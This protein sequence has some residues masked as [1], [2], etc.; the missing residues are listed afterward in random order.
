MYQGVIFLTEVTM[1]DQ[2]SFPEL[3]EYLSMPETLIKFLLLVC[4]ECLVP[5]LV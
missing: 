2:K 3:P 4:A 1:S 5:D